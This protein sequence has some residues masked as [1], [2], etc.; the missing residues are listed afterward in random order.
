MCKSGTKKIWKKRKVKKLLRFKLRQK[1]FYHK[2]GGLPVTPIEK[3]TAEYKKVK[4][5]EL[6]QAAR[7]P[8]N[9][10]LLF[11]T[12]PKPVVNL[13]IVCV[14][15]SVCLATQTHI[16]VTAGRNYVTH[17]PPTLGPRGT[18]KFS[19]V[20]CQPNVYWCPS[21]SMFVPNFVYA[22]F[23]TVFRQWLSNFQIW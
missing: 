17:T 16:S 23:P 14:Y 18:S 11:T 12:C 20:S 3:L 5:Y 8:R 13:E 2:S 9:Y 4:I 1:Y 19:V 21:A 7:H 6:Q 10:R 22:I 15:L